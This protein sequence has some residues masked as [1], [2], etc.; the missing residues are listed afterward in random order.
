MSAEIELE[1]LNIIFYEKED[2]TKPAKEFIDSLDKKIRAKVYSLLDML[3]ERGRWI[4]K[5][6]L[7]LIASGIHE[8]RTHTENTSQIL[9]FFVTGNY[10]AI[11]TNGFIK[12]RKT[13]SEELKKAK[14]YKRNYLSRKVNELIMS[15]NYEDHLQ[16]QMK[17]PEF[18]AAYYDIQP[19][20]D[21]VRAIF[22]AY[23]LEGFNK[24]L[25]SEQSGLSQYTISKLEAADAN[26]SLSTLK[27]LA[28]AMGKK[29]HIEFQ[30]L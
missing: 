12:T 14:Q 11:F 29:L 3:S 5:P 13:T 26:P 30:P 19:D 16:E 24:E 22:D 9:Y 23:D 25:L 10:S 1:P 2:G 15:T 8:L 4:R 21:I 27:K 18:R 20:F 28:R 17:D 7:K 6:Y